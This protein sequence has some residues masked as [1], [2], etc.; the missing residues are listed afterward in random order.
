[1]IVINKKLFLMKKF[2]TFI[3]LISTIVI[4]AQNT[5]P[6]PIEQ[7]TEM[8]FWWK[9][10]SIVIGLGLGIGAYMLIKKNPRKDAV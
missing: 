3:F 4:Q 2:L 8:S 5:T 10:I 9:V 7:T 6:A 1:M